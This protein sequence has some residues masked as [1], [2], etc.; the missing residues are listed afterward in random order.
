MQDSAN[1]LEGG[2]RSRQ[3][4]QRPSAQNKIFQFLIVLNLSHMPWLN[5]FSLI[6]S[7]ALFST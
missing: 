1:R 3:F 5:I 4:E 7:C 2:G 6:F